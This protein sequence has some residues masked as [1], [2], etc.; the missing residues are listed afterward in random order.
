MIPKLPGNTFNWGERH[1][2]WCLAQAGP[3]VVRHDSARLRGT[4]WSPEVPSNPFN[5]VILWP[6]V[7]CSHNASFSI[8]CEVLTSPS[9]WTAHPEG[10]QLPRA[11]LVQLPS[12]VSDQQQKPDSIAVIGMLTTKSEVEDPTYLSKS[13]L[14]DISG[15]QWGNCCCCMDLCLQVGQVAT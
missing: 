2:D 1:G 10:C 7:C 13:I 9:D 6:D 5:S 14:S 3:S 15:L 8:N 11:L 12:P 4:R